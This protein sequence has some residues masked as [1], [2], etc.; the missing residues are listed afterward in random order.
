MKR[1]ILTA[2]VI[3]PAFAGFSVTR[4]FAPVNFGIL[5][6]AAPNGSSANDGITPNTPWS[7]SYA[8]AQAGPSTII[9]LLPGTYPSIEISNP[10]TKLVCRTKWAARVVGSPGVNGIWTDSNVGNVIIDGIEVVG[11]ALDGIALN[12]SNC[13]VRNCWVHN[14]SGS[15]ITARLNSNTLLERNLIEGNGLGSLGGHGINLSGTNCIVRA[16]VLRYNQGWGCQI[17]EPAPNSCAE[18]DFYNNLVYGNQSGLTVWSPA[19]QTNYVFNNTILSSTNYCLVADFGNLCVSNNILSSG[20]QN[21]LIGVADGANVWSDYNLLSASASLGGLHSLVVAG[22]AFVNAPSGLYWLT[23][24]S[25]ARFVANPAVIPPVDFFGKPESSVTDV[26][27][28]QFSSA[29]AADT[30][31]LDPSPTNGADYWAPPPAAVSNPPVI[32]AQ[33][34][35]ETVNVGDAATFS[36]NVSGDAPLSYQ[37]TFMGSAVGSNSSSYTRSGCQLVDNGGSVSVTVSNTSGSVQSSAATLTVNGGK[38]YYVSLT[39][40]TSNDGLS[41]NS[42]WTLSY[43]LA[44]AGASNTIVLMDGG[45]YGVIDL[46][47][48]SNHCGLVIKA[49]NKWKAFITG[50]PAHHCYV[51]EYGVSNCVVDGIHFVYSYQD[52]LYLTGGGIVQNCWIAGAARPPGWTTNGNGG[53]GSGI[54]LSRWAATNTPTTIIQYSLVE[55]NGASLSYDQGLYLSASNCIVRGN[56]IRY[57][58]A[59]GC[60]MTSSYTDTIITGDQFYN[61]LVYGNGRGNGAHE[62]YDCIVVDCNEKGGTVVAGTNW[63]YNN[64]LVNNG[65]F[66]VVPCYNGTVY[67]TNNIIIGG[68][69]AGYSGSIKIVSGI[70]YADYN[71]ATNSFAGSGAVDGGHNIVTSDCGFVNAA[72]GLWWLTANSPARGQSV[73]QPGPVDFFGNVQSSVTDIGPFHYSQPYEADSRVLDPSPDYPDFW[74]VK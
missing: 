54:Y 49:Q 52:D 32:T 38:Q 69:G 30:R 8:L 21:M 59:Y 12:G 22:P 42:P 13:V 35:N 46:D 37:W 3:L 1:A 66:P 23:A 9:A 17:Y 31:V 55:S 11:S 58:L 68:N 14:S 60:Q 6:Y 71:L 29:L 26:G 7:L 34:T 62:G 27:A 28:F 33:P 51:T 72:N 15:G 19:G 43:A 24:A 18:C 64:I 40:S 67:L 41:T 57:N 4:P 63:I 61:N 16:N 25:L 47:T 48:P 2:L 45:P 50:T 73:N 36:V 70:G 20:S 39:G 65:P 10:G 5:R 74:L 53:T 56:V 44:N